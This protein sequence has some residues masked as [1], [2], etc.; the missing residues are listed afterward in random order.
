[1]SDTAAVH[2]TPP[3]SPEDAARADLYGLVARLFYAP[4]DGNLL[5]ELRLAAPQAPAGESLTAEGK[6][7]TQAWAGLVEAC[8]QAFP[9][10]LEEEHLEL[11]V[12]VGKAEV[13]PY[14]SAYLAHAESD[15]PLARLRG[16]LAELGLERRE[17]V[18]EPEDHISAVCEVMR[19]LIVGRRAKL[20]AQR[21]FFEEYVHPGGSGFCTAVSAC[22]QAKFY[23]HPARL[24]QAFLDV[25]HKAFDI[26]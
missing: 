14:L 20:D 1:M 19:W 8:A 21:R 13:T 25:E 23:R 7:L 22:E 12:G 6:A 10:R 16:R 17:K 5:S 26:D 2:F 9:A 15:R 3:V 4:P 24:L 18:V 11:F